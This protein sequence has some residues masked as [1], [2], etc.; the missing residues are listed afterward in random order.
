M[1]TGMTLNKTSVKP[2]HL[3]VF[4]D[5]EW[6]DLQDEHGNVLSG[7]RGKTGAVAVGSDGVEVGCDLIE[8]QPGSA[9]PA[10]THA[11][12]H[13]LYA[14]SGEGNV[15]VGEET[16]HFGTG[17]TFYISAAIPHNVGTYPGH[18]GSFVLLAFGHPHKEVSATDRMKLVSIDETETELPPD[19]PWAGYFPEQKRQIHR[20]TIEFDN[21][22]LN[23]RAVRYQKVRTEG[24][25]FGETRHVILDS[26]DVQ[27]GHES[28]RAMAN[29]LL[30]F[31]K[32]SVKWIDP[33][34]PEE[35]L[36]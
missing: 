19:L 5:R 33:P 36:I 9:F 29:H 18:G 22:R 7:I 23:H 8:M 4:A 15:T 30:S 16:Y 35:E 14:V 25:L 20:F 17:S 28:Y 26:Q 6:E 27:P 13:I 31:G 24:V 32:F 3:V 10:H 21:S 1:D 2:E 11:G 12:D 34:P